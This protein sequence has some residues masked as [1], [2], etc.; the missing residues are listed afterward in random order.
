[1]AKMK[2]LGKFENKTEGFTII[3]DG[4]EHF[5]KHQHSSRFKAS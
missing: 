2:E 1:M 3:F 5:G 4:S